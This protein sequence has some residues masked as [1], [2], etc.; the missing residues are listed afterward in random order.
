MAFTSDSDV[1]VK[2]MAWLLSWNHRPA[3][4]C[5]DSV[6]TS[7]DYCY[8]NFEQSTQ[9]LSGPQFRRL[10]NQKRNTHVV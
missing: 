4:T 9:K 10:F 1:R 5:V 8:S 3:D 6:S 7:T 2:L